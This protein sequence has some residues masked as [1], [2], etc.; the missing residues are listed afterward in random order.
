M[1]TNNHIMHFCALCLGLLLPL[2][3]VCAF[4]EG[5]TD[6]FCFVF[7]NTGV[8]D[9]FLSRGQIPDLAKWAACKGLCDP[10]DHTTFLQYC[11]CYFQ[12]G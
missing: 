6:T 11:V 9:H 10:S 7:L 4:G 3:H 12:G 8:E 5:S 2:N 1:L